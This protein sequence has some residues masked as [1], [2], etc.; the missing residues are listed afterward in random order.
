MKNWKKPLSIL[1]TT[2]LLSGVL[3]TA[4][5]DAA[6]TIKKVDAHYK[7]IKIVNNSEEIKVDPLTEPFILNGVTYIPLRMMGELYNKNVQ[8]NGTTNTVTVTDKAPAVNQ[9]QATIDVLNAQISVKDAQIKS[10]DTQIA[11][12][13]AEIN[14]LKEEQKNQKDE[15]NQKDRSFS[16]LERQLNKDYDDYYR[17]LRNVDIT[18]SGDS[19][20]TTVRIDVNSSD[21]NNLTSTKKKDF[22]QDIIDDIVAEYKNT[23]I[24][25][26]IRDTRNGNQ[27]STF[28]TDSRNNLRLTEGKSLYDLE[29]Q[30]NREYRNN[31]DVSNID[32]IL[33]GNKDRV[34]LTI[35]VNATDWSKLSSRDKSKFLQDIADD[36]FYEYRNALIDG[37]IED[38]SNGKR[39]NTFYADGDG[40]GKAVIN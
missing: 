10:K 20:K 37:V 38:Y 25:G 17:D 32:I 27:L 39:L 6:S 16:D 18:L 19:K 22:L 30:L 4:S 36:I 5:T 28:D 29:N 3:F 33:D 14:K 8:W 7:N 40:S 15:K 34:K 13:Q 24:T 12:L 11:Q 26:T 35:E 23:T 9:N 21:W 1:S 31:R 2:A